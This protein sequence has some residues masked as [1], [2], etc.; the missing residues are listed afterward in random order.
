[1]ETKIYQRMHKDKRVN[2]ASYFVAKFLGEA[3]EADF[4]DQTFILRAKANC[5]SID[6]I[7]DLRDNFDDDLH[8]IEDEWPSEEELRAG[9][10]KY[11]HMVQV[12]PL[13]LKEIEAFDL[14][15]LVDRVFDEDDKHLLEKIEAMPEKLQNF[16][17]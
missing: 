17:I 1:M 12:Y 13:T 11:C 14:H 4:K 3:H 8:F 7:D 10:R 6:L 15:E 9:D 2:Y 5:S 16:Y